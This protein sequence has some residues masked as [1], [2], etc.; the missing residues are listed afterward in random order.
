VAG[1]LGAYLLWF[2]GATVRVVI[3]FFVLI[4]I[5]L[6]IPAWIMIGVWFV[7]NLLA[8]YATIADAAEP[9]QGVAWFAHIGGFLFGML[10]AA[11]AGRRPYRR[12][13]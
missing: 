12:E 6:P 3:P 5:P 10:V 4:F 13:G 9:G 11:I 2:P 7:Q 1:V 8:G